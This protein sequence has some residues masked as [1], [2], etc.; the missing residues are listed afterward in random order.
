ME[1]YKSNH[2]LVL[3]DPDTSTYT[4]KLSRNSAGAYDVCYSSC[5]VPEHVVVRT[6][7]YAVVDG[8]HRY[9]VEITFDHVGVSYSTVLRFN[10]EKNTFK[11]ANIHA[12]FNKDDWF[13]AVA[14]ARKHFHETQQ[15]GLVER[16]AR[17]KTDSRE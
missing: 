7:T 3:F 11:Q 5:M 16:M 10:A 13:K 8:Q 6:K 9:D 2:S 1:L 15:R 12:E 17:L 14:V 4:I